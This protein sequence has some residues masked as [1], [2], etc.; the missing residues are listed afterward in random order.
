MLNLELHKPVG[1]DDEDEVEDE[2]AD[3]RDGDEGLPAIR[4]REGAW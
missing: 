1:V 2:V 3:E 4:V